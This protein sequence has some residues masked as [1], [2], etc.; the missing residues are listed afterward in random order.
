MAD[1]Y[2]YYE[3]PLKIEAGG[4][5]EMLVFITLYDFTPHETVGLKKTKSRIIFLLLVILQQAYS[6]FGN[7]SVKFSRHFVLPQHSALVACATTEL[8]HHRIANNV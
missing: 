1:T 3:K 8:C 2:Q 6:W 5:S 7:L 4:T